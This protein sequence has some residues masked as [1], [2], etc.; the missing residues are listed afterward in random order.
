MAL[1]MVVVLG[2]LI[3]LTESQVTSATVS[4]SSRLQL[5]ADSILRNMGF[6]VNQ[7]GAM[8][9]VD[10]GP[11]NVVFSNEFTGFNPAAPGMAGANFL[12]VHGTNG[13]GSNGSDLLR[14]S[15]EDNGAV[16]D[17][18][19]MTT[20]T[21]A[22]SGTSRV[23]NQFWLAGNALMCQGA[24]NGPAQAVADGVEDLQ[25]L[26]TLRSVVAGA[27]SFRSLSADQVPAGQWR[28]VSAITIC[29]R[30][31]GA[32]S[33]LPAQA[34]SIGCQG[35]TI[36]ADGRLRRVVTRTFAIRNVLP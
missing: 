16:R 8:E 36:A 35:E 33:N 31:A 11:G 32:L 21:P 7:G 29:L 30:L 12:H 27:P 24:G 28:E 18:I 20:A 13:T 34:A 10:S 4:D 3:I 15:F 17:C 19:G 6:Q 2:G 1:G 26:F 5:K 22:G 23:D 14:V 25:L 9:L